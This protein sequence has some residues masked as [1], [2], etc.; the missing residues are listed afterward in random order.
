MMQCRK[1]GE[2]RK[3]QKEG[4]RERRGEKGRGGLKI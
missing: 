3:K 2:R 4:G 1:E